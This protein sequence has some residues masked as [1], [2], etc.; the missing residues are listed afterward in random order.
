MKMNKPPPPPEEQ[1]EL[2][3]ADDTII[4]KAVRGSLVV[5]TVIAVVVIGLEECAEL[6]R[7][8]GKFHSPVAHLVKL[9]GHHRV[10]KLTH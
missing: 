9:Q 8:L 2:V 4:G 10:D 6:C 7:L 1:E 5:G 3:H